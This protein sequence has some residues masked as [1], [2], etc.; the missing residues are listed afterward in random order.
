MISSVGNLQLKRAKQRSSPLTGTLL[1]SWR[2]RRMTHL[3]LNDLPAPGMKGRG[4]ASSLAALATT[5]KH[6]QAAGICP[7]PVTAPLAG[8][9]WRRAPATSL[10]KN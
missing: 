9:P 6:V 10:G 3:Q 4:G 1:S 8:A 2:D 7:R 5:E